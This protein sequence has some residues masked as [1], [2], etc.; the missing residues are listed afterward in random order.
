MD[1]A[2]R[3]SKVLETSLSHSILTDK[4][5]KSFYSTF[6]QWPQGTQPDLQQSDDQQAILVMYFLKLM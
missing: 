3:N 5:D 1:E 6:D 4:L 2:Y